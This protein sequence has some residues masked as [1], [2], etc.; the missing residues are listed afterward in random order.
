MKG[1][2]NFKTGKIFEIVLGGEQKMF[3][4]GLEGLE[5]KGIRGSR[6]A[7]T[8]CTCSHS[9]CEEIIM[10]F[11]FLTVLFICFKRMIL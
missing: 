8:T 1:S 9:S 3:G 2:R 6:T 10:F 4:T 7:N 11:V 5:D